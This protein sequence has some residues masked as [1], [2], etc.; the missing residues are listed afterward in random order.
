MDIS[1]KNF[2]LGFG[3]L[4]LIFSCTSDPLKHPNVV[5]IIVDDLGWKDLGCYGSTFYE[6]PT[7]DRFAKE[8][9][10]FTNAYAAS[11]VCSPT[12]AAIM[13]GKHP[14][15]LNITDWIPGMKTQNPKLLTPED[16]YE[17]PHKEFTIAEALKE[18]G[19]KTFFAGKWHLGDENF[20]PTDQGFDYNFGG[21]H[22]G[23]P[24]GGY[25]VPYNNPML[26]DGPEGEYLTDR[27][28][29]E[30][31][32]F[33]EENKD[34]PF[35]LCLSFYNV[36]TPLEPNKEF[37]KRFEA[38][39]TNLREENIPES[40]PERDGFTD[41]KQD[42]PVYASM[43]SV[44]D[45]NV[46]KLL[47]E[48]KSAGLDENT[49][50]IFTS[51]NG[52]LTTLRKKTSPTSVL[53]LRAG[54][55][56]C[57]EGGI[58][59]PLIIRY[60]KYIEAGSE[61]DAIFMSQDIFPTI[62]DLAKLPLYPKIHQDGMSQANVLKG[63]TV[64]VRNTAFWHYPHYHGSA[65]TPGAAVREGDWKLIRFYEYEE[66]ELFN[67]STDIGE[68]NNLIKQHPEKAKAL[69]DKLV[70]L[71]LESNAQLPTSNPNYLEE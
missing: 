69:E 13:T 6:T 34:N 26:P 11:P 55:G 58:R 53:P 37:I 49:L 61:S 48:L 64:F 24:P 1:F 19:Y 43:V 14:A 28:T 4:L 52:G 5:L 22:K 42:N 36:H 25:Y 9:R 17:L 65:W 67:L 57:Y 60:P 63:D 40:I 30:S 71:Q 33:I 3:I 35:F 47:N 18:N 21:H 20:L 7:I 2:K 70:Q 46:G 54:K 12:R 23:S 38:K 27:L 62:L 32:K 50:V 31:V 15:R 68:K 8:S 29:D 10:L 16:L 41:I 66:T 59:I 44:V 39:L 56:W 45:K 51:D